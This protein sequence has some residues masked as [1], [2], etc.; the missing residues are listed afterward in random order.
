ME[1]TVQVWKKQFRYGRNSSGLE[2][3]VKVWQNISGIEKP[4]QV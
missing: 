1:E 4:V 3:T 2:E